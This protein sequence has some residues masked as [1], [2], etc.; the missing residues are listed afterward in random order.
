MEMGFLFFFFF[1]LGE[2]RLELE[3]EG[4]GH[5]WVRFGRE[6]RE[7]ERVLRRESVAWALNRVRGW[8]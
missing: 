1:F 2:E 4:A 3:R 5:W 7:R 6:E 8:E